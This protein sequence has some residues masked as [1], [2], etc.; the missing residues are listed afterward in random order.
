MLVAPDMD[1]DWAC[2]TG[3]KRPRKRRAAETG[4]SG[5]REHKGRRLEVRPM[6]MMDDG[7]VVCLARGSGRSRE[8]GQ[9][10]KLFLCVFEG[11]RGGEDSVVGA[12]WPWKEHKQV[13][14]GERPA[15][16]AQARR[17]NEQ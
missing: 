8:A 16:G 5:A 6:M 17:C 15:Q 14:T 3:V 4:R 10:A 9:A 11:W 7:R 12:K 13:N 1:G 2:V